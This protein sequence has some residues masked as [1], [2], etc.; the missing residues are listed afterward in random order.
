M[1][2]FLF[3]LGLGCGLGILFAPMSGEQTRRNLA[4]RANDLADTA[5]ETTDQIRDRVR[6]GM[7]AIRGGTERPTGTEGAQQL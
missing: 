7:S 4:D 3:G 5:R 6:S 1:K 2:A